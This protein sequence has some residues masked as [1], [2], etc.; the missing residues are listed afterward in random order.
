MNRWRSGL[1]GLLLVWLV[2][3][4]SAVAARAHGPTVVLSEAGFKPVLLN[5]FEGT[6][7]HFTNT[8]AGPEGVVLADEGGAFSSPPITAA[9]DGWH[10]TFEK[11][12]TFEIRVAGR[13]EAK[14]RIVVV[15]KPGT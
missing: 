13:P 14:L 3:M 8:I 12:G 4:G 11:I 10:Y 9:S 6:T 2:L 15:K 7:V 5:L 1:A